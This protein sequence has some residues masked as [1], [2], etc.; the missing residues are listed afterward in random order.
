MVFWPDLETLKV[1]C[2]V[3]NKAG[4]KMKEHGLKFYYHNHF[5]EFSYLGDKM[6][7]DLIAETQ[8]QTML[9]LSLIPIGWYVL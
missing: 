1:R 7:W 4:K 2:D 5:H 6:V 9:A 8:I 3:M